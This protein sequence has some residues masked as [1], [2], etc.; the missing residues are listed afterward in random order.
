MTKLLEGNGAGLVRER[1]LA[2]VV[3]TS[4]ER[5]YQLEKIPCVSEFVSLAEE[6]EGLFV[7]EEGGA[8][9]MALHLPPL[10]KKD[11]DLEDDQSLDPMCQLI[12]GVSH[13]VYLADRVTASREATQLELE[14]QAEVDKYVFLSYALRAFHPETSRSLRT[15]L[16]EGI[17]Y[18]HEAS[19][20]QGARYRLANETAHRFVHRLETECLARGRIGDFLGALRT[21]FRSGQEEKLRHAR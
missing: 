19:T 14:V 10:Q 9:E 1:A 5:T 4:L 12:E 16:Y 8:V 11:F 7:R 20:E 3:Q 6:R 17:R 15:R 18:C 13:F 2:K 21:F